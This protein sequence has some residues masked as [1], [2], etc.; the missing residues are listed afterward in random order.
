MPTRTGKRT[1]SAIA[2]WLVVA[3]MTLILFAPAGH[4]AGA[5]STEIRVALLISTRGTVPA[6]TFESASPLAVAVQGSDASGPVIRVEAHRQV[7][8]SLSGYALVV[9]ETADIAAA[10]DAYHAASPYGHA[11]ILADELQ[12]RTMYQVR[13]SGFAN[14]A[15]AESAANR[16][17]L[18]VSGAPS[19]AGP[20]YAS[21]ATFANAAEAE[22]MAAFLSGQGIRAWTAVHSD[23]DGA[24]GYSVWIGESATSGDLER[25]MAAVRTVL[26][27]AALRQVDGTVPYLVHRTEIAAGT[28]DRIV[29]YRFNPSGQ[30]IRISGDGSSPI[31][32]HERYGRTYRGSMAVTAH[33]GKLAVINV[34]PLE[35][36]LYAVVGSEMP[37]SWP[38]EALKAQAVAARTYAR[39][40]GLQYKIAH[41]S[42]T[43]YDQAYLGTSAESQRSIEAVEATR[44]EVLKNASGTLIEAL[45][46]SNHGGMSADPSEVW[47]NGA[48]HLKRVSSP[49]QVAE[50]GKLVWYRIMLADGTSGYIRS[51][52]AVETGTKS[53]S[54]LP[55]IEVTGDGVNIRRAPRVDNTDNPAVA[56][57][58][59][60]DRF[61]VIGR[62]VESN[63]YSWIRGPY[64]AEQLKAALNGRSANAVQG[65]LTT[66]E[67][68]GRGPSGR[69][70]E[71][72]ANGKSVNVS[73]PDLYR[74]ALNGLPSTL[75]DIEETGR[76]SVLAAFG[77]KR[78]YTE[79]GS[80]LTVLSAKGES[81]LAGNEFYILDGKGNVRAAT[82]APA[83]RFIGRGFGHGLGLSQYGALSLAESGYD[84]RDILA[85]Y[86]DGVIIAKE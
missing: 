29:H 11:E 67:V 28:K 40:K 69:V 45:Y 48:S 77:S 31:K 12:G 13:L 79:A 44:G 27:G 38:L 43:T 85:Y 74:N 47:G 49:D 4:A 56:Q 34:L 8:F 10:L 42:D 25:E 78:E 14:K 32:V 71:I 70:T 35:Q 23:A 30:E 16:L 58:N 18:A 50:R 73:Y 33:E 68:T 54:G 1:N 6:A 61:T 83:F 86:Y 3:L 19:V 72:A 66:L 2:G 64:T 81:R 15:E 51:D 5:E 52:Y 22:T 57:A 84:Y 24:G 21:V 75:F 63:A 76:F 39:S 65:G 37:G 17:P 80:G 46:A 59:R 20:L 41:V 26:P 82:T 7:R 9:R 60:G 55:V 53:E 62:D 36:Y